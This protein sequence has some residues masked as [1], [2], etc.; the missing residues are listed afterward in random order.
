MVMIVIG[1]RPIAVRAG[2]TIS[3]FLAILCSQAEPPNELALRLAPESFSPG[4]YALSISGQS[5][6]NF[7]LETSSDLKAWEIQYQSFGWPGTNAVQRIGPSVE[8]RS[9]QFVR[10]R[11]GESLDALE[12]RWLEN[13]PTEY[14]FRLQSE[15]CLCP[16]SFH[17]TVRVRNGSV[18]EVT[19]AMDDFTGEPIPRPDL[20]TFLTITQLFEE[21]RREVQGGSEQVQVTYDPSGLFPAR[22]FI[23]RTLRAADD[24]SAIDAT[25]FAVV[26]P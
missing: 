13:E 8:G 25:H 11:P 23:D 2:V 6:T 15:P 19:D 4:W 5:T 9:R 16:G 20:S 3:L 22:V 18:V 26:E 17:G 10:A 24:E 21:I 7:L 12:Q 1:S 14:T